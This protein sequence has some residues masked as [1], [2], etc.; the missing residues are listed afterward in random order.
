MAADAF[1]AHGLHDDARA[2][3]EKALAA[4]WDEQAGA[5]LSP[6]R[7]AGRFAGA[8]WRRS[9]AAKQWAREHPSDAELALTLGTL[10]LKQKFWGKAQRHLEQA[11]SDATEPDTVREVHLKLAQLHESLNRPGTG[12]PCAITGNRPGAY[13]K[14]RE[15]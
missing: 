12:W 10:C 5:R 14:C 11:L 2:V 7:R 8:C 1:N 3:I 15:L 13:G 9:S 6:R 4:E